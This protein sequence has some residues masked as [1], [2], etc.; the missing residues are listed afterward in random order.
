M[1]AEVDVTIGTIARFKE[2]YRP[3]VALSYDMVE[4]LS[5]DNGMYPIRILSLF[6]LTTVILRCKPSEL[7]ILW[8]T[9]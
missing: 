9:E 3:R 7:E 6:R 2:K 1:A 5:I 8:A 4:V